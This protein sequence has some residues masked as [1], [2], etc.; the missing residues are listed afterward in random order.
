MF[1]IAIRALAQIHNKRVIEMINIQVDDNADVQKVKEIVLSFNDAGKTYWKKR[2]TIKVFNFD[3]K[4]WNVKSFKVPHLINR[5]AYKYI[6]GSKSKRSFEHGKKILSLGILTPKP[7]GYVEYSNVIGLEESFYV[8]EN[9]NYDLKFENLFDENYPDRVNLLE[10]FTEFTYQLHENGIHHFDHSKGNTLMVK[11]P[12]GS[13]DFYLVDLNRMKFEKMD[14]QQRID[15][16][17]RLSLTPYM[18][19]VIGSKYASITGLYRVNINAMTTA[20]CAKFHEFKYRKM[21]WKKKL[22][23][24]L[25]PGS[26]Q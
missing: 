3:E 25:A 4:Q 7:I 12:D 9:L 19:D 2:N 15:N 13:Y 8:S 18:I 10:Q 11:K 24:S 5:F 1:S 6:R 16:F 23:I 26:G 22:G 14:Y 21:R 20:S 17:N